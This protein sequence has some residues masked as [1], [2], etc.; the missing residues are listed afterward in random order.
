[1]PGDYHILASIHDEIG[2]GGFANQM[3]GRLVDYAQRNGWMGRQIVDLG[4]GSGESLL[5]LSQHHYIVT[6]V[7]RSPEMLNLA[8]SYLA[9][10]NVSASLTQGDFRTLNNI[11]G[12]DMVLALNVLSELDNIRALEQAFKHIHGMLRDGRW[13]VFDMYTIE[14][15]V[16]RN[17]AGYDLE[18]DSDGLTIFVSNRF[19]YEKS[20]Q[21]RDYIIFRQHDT[22]W[23]RLEA[24]RSLRAYPI[25]GVTALVQRSGFNVHHVLNM[26]MS[27]HKPSNSTPRV[28]IFASKK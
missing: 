4:C 20:I 13:L 1:M 9:Q 3:T 2:M 7:D 10:N 18:H 28:L 12:Q 26:D 16:T 14:G 6:G 15:L 27:D 25:Q 24:Q 8:K 21:Y 22:G 17:Q 5:W 19:D 11:S 23:E